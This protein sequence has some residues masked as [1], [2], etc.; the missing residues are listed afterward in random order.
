MGGINRADPIILKEAR[1]NFASRRDKIC[2]F[3]SHIRI[4]KPA[5]IA[6]GEYIKDNGGFD[7]YLDVY[8]D[9]LQRADSEHNH[10]KITAYIEKGINECTHILCLVSNETKQ[11]WWVPY[12]IGYAKKGSKDIASLI[13][14][15]VETL[16][17][18]LNIERIIP[19]TK[20]LNA[21]LQSI[22]AV[23]TSGRL[24][25]A[26]RQEIIAATTTSH[27]LDNYLNWKV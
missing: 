26:Y 20:S 14:K 12:E 22:V 18:F 21:Y 6:I 23:V 1:Y 13:L 24:N 25:E 19:G 7:I 11:S 17:S 9:E 15:D 3:I 27:P 2:I 5:A 16:P 10:K 8:D 4:D